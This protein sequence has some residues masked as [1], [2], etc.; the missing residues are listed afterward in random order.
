MIQDI[1]LSDAQVL[2]FKRGQGVGQ[3]GI[4]LLR[5]HLAQLAEVSRDLTFFSAGGSSVSAI[6]R[7]VVV[8]APTSTSR[9]VSQHDR[10]RL[11]PFVLVILD[12]RVDRIG[13]HH[14]P[15]VALRLGGSGFNHEAAGI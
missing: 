10:R 11:G 7:N 8:A 9:G 14:F 12:E 6:R 1:N 15:N 4:E 13:K 3:P 5:T 2:G